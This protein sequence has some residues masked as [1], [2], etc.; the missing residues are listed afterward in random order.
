MDSENLILHFKLYMFD[1]KDSQVLQKKL[2]FQQQQFS[3]TF[4]L[5]KSFETHIHITFSQFFIVNGN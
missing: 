1:F 4:I 3:E 2:T 5:E